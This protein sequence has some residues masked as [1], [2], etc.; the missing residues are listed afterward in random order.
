MV[1]QLG[2]DREQMVLD[3][4][5]QQFR[6]GGEVVKQAALR[7]ARARGNRVEREMADA[8]LA[9]DIGGRLENSCAGGRASRRHRN[10]IRGY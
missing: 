8:G 2:L 7:Q 4:R 6:L 9:G 10:L 1:V 5:L 3:Q